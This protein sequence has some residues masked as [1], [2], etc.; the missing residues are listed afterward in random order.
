MIQVKYTLIAGMNNAGTHIERALATGPRNL[1]KV[2]DE[3]PS[4]RKRLKS[5]YGNVGCSRVWVEV[6]GVEI[7]EFDLDR[8]RSDI[9]ELEL[10]DWKAR[11]NGLCSRPV[12]P[13]ERAKAL[14]SSL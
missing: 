7:D 8:L 1:A 4:I 6:D 3:F 13:T 14:L 12:P 5:A 2:A 10:A 9:Y 11:D